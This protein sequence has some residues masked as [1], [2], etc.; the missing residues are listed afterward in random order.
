MQDQK[1][2][3]ELVELQATLDQPVSQEMQD[4]PDSKDQQDQLDD[5]EYLELRVPKVTQESASLDHVDLME[6]QD[7]LEH[8]ELRE[9]Q[10]FQVHKVHPEMF[11]LMEN[12]S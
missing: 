12:A 1:D 6:H 10:D 4:N 7:L 11:L 5:Q 2:L 8:Q 9:H 3:R